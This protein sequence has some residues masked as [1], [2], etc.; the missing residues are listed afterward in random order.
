MTPDR[1][2]KSLAEIQNR[3]LYSQI[4]PNVGSNGERRRKDVPWTG[5]IVSGDIGPAEGHECEVYDPIEGCVADGCFDYRF[6][7]WID[8]MGDIHYVNC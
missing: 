7:A 2:A 5:L 8:H 4:L 3:W 6:V 1:L